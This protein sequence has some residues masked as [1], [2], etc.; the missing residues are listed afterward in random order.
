M[1]SLWEYGALVVIL[2]VANVVQWKEN[3]YLT[4]LLIDLNKEYSEAISELKKLIMG[5]HE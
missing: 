5:E 3:K 1:G 2:F 4:H